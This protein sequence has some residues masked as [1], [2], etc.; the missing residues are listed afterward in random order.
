MRAS[1]LLG[2]Q[3]TA[4]AG[5][6]SMVYQVRPHAAGD[7]VVEGG[8]HMREDY[9]RVPLLWLRGI[10]FGVRSVRRRRP[11]FKTSRRAGS[12]LLKPPRGSLMRSPPPL[13]S[14]VLHDAPPL[15]HFR[16]PGRSQAD[17]LKESVPAVVDMLADTVLNPKFLP[18]E[19]EE[20][21][22]AVKAE[23]D[24]AAKNPQVPNRIPCQRCPMFHED[25]EPQPV[26]TVGS[27]TGP[28]R[29]FTPDPHANP[30]AA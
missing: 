26:T 23:L 24:D 25:S 4:I 20:E 2:A 11:R 21:K 29:L 27:S 28:A 5:R 1:E 7:A 16:T 8:H 9:R 18:W 22:A 19:L 14:S 15:S 17:A 6:E 12:P 30:P 10:H 13:A 3:L